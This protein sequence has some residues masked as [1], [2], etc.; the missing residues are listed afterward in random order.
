ME[1]YMIHL[2]HLYQ[3]DRTCS[4]KDDGRMLGGHEMEGAPSG[5]TGDDTSIKTIVTAINHTSLSKM[6]CHCPTLSY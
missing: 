2:E 6:G 1:K 5:Q 3:E 4:K